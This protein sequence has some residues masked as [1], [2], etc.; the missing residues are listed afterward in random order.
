MD[1]LKDPRIKDRIVNSLQ[2]RV[3]HRISNH[4]NY[5]MY[6]A[7]DFPDDIREEI[8]EFLDIALPKMM[9]VPIYEIVKRGKVERRP[10]QTQQMIQYLRKCSPH[11]KEADPDLLR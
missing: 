10:D 6:Q 5:N 4:Q 11:F 2:Y 8:Q 9:K 1:D 7:V 3:Q